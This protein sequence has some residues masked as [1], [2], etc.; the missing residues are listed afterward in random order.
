MNM[1]ANGL[2]F[3][4]R[5]MDLG[6]LYFEGKPRPKH[7][8]EWCTDLG[9]IPHKQSTIIIISWRHNILVSASYSQYHW[10]TFPFINKILWPYKPPDLRQKLC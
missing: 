5:G 9:F 2:L 10:K 1:R 8:L 6:M 7:I 4:G 3:L